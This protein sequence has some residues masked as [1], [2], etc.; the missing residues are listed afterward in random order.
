MIPVFPCLPSAPATLLKKLAFVILLSLFLGSHQ[1]HASRTPLVLLG[2][3]VVMASLGMI[4]FF[5]DDTHDQNVRHGLFDQ[6]MKIMPRITYQVE[7]PDKGDSGT[8]LV[9]TP[10]ITRGHYIHAGSFEWNVNSFVERVICDP[11]S[12]TKGLNT[13][14]SALKL[15]CQNWFRDHQ[16]MH[17]PHQL[18][19]IS[20]DKLD[21][22]MLPKLEFDLKKNA[23]KVLVSYASYMNEDGIPD[24]VKP[25]VGTPEN[26]QHLIPLIPGLNPESNT[27]KSP[28]KL[29]HHA[30]EFAGMEEPSFIRDPGTRQKYPYYHFAVP[31]ISHL[32]K[33]DME[34][35]IVTVAGKSGP[36]GYYWQVDQP[37]PDSY[38]AMSFI[39]VKR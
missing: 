7:Q 11:I 30:P 3:V 35:F 25:K 21:T 16:D 24:K 29:C 31:G 12:S 2:T 20:V 4:G 13:D 18:L 34:F 37:W 22:V 32:H 17:F 15:Q 36:E 14:P 19:S 28:L 10:T 1:A 27:R 5:Y 6:H 8:K 26:W 38:Q 33:T 9:L 23:I 39:R